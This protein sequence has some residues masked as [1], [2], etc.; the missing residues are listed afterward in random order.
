[1][2]QDLF[3]EDPTTA[4]KASNENGLWFAGQ[5]PEKFKRYQGEWVCISQKRITSHDED[6]G[7]VLIESEKYEDALIVKIRKPGIWIL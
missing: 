7:K 4:D 6:L 5:H 3:S 2:E 1:M